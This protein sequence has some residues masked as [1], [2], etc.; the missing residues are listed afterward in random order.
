MNKE[1]VEIILD[2][3]R[4]FEANYPETLKSGFNINCPKVFTVLFNLIK[5]FLTERTLSKISI[6]DSNSSKWRPQLEKVV[7]LGLL[8]EKYGGSREKIGK[9]RV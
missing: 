5:P 1:V 6:F 9:S 8:P 3:A 7:D 2:A 4:S